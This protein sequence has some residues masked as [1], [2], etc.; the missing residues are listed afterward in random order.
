MSDH[1]P[2]ELCCSEHYPLPV[3]AKSANEH[4][5]EAVAKILE[6][7]GYTVS[8]ETPSCQSMPFATVGETEHPMYLYT[9]LNGKPVTAILLSDAGELLR[10]RTENKQLRAIVKEYCGLFAE[11]CEEDRDWYAKKNEMDTLKRLGEQAK[12]LG[13]EVN[14]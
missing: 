1:E 10:L 11:A 6:R 3:R 9:V 12:A 2:Y 14:E 8:T 13:I 4:L 7:D 5:T